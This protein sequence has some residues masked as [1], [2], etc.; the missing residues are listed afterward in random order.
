MPVTKVIWHHFAAFRH[1]V[2]YQLEPQSFIVCLLAGSALRNLR[3]SNPSQFNFRYRGIRTYHHRCGGATKCQ[4][5]YA[6]KCKWCLFYS[7]W[8]ESKD[9]RLPSENEQKEQLEQ[10]TSSLQH[11]RVCAYWHEF[12][13]SRTGVDRIS[14]WNEL[15][16]DILLRDSILRLW[17]ET[18]ARTWCMCDMWRLTTILQIQV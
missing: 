17:L 2:S 12:I 10:T 9:Y 7:R 18:A 4:W 5:W 15:N 16:N 3:H 8:S 6:I 11:H 13:W 1:L 14:S